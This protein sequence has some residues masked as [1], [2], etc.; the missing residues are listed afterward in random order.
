VLELLS[1]CCFGWEKFISAIG[2][3]WCY[4]KNDRSR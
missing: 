3:G 4:Q 1:F 2:A